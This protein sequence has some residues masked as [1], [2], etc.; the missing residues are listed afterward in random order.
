MSYSLSP[1]A[2]AD[3]DGIWNYTADNW[4]IEQADRYIASIMEACASISIDGR[5]GRPIPKVRKGYCKLAVGTHFI[6]F[7]LADS[8]VDIV[9]ILHQRMDIPAHLER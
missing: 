2:E 7:R 8:H 3:L 1:A 6:V 9:R 5:K 4:S